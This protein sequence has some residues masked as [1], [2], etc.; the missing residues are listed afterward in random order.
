[1]CLEFQLRIRFQNF[2][3]VG[4]VELNLANAFV[5]RLPD[6]FGELRQ[7]ERLDLH[8]NEISWLPTTFVDLNKLE[9]FSTGGRP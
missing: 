5:T 3:Q 1:M 8:N 6:N 9:V 4:L 2:L 7:L